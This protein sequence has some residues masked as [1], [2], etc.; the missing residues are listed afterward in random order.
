MHLT[1]VHFAN[2]PDQFRV[3]LE[4]MPSGA[5]WMDLA[6]WKFN[7]TVEQLLAVRDAIDA[8]LSRPC[9]VVSAA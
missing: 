3:K 4:D 8:H 7:M 1:H 5:V 6:D 2:Y 9:I